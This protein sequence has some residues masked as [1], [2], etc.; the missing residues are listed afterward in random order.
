MLILFYLFQNGIDFIRNRLS[1]QRE[2]FSNKGLKMRRNGSSK[3]WYGSV[4]FAL[5][6]AGALPCPLITS[7]STAPRS[8]L[9]SMTLKN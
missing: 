4:C 8:Q 6:L 2:R 3:G 1:N 9:K 7:T 5:D